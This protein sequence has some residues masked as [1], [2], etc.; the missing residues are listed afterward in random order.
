MLHPLRYFAEN[1]VIRKRL[2]EV[3]CNHFIEKQLF[4]NYKRL[5][6]QLKFSKASTTNNTITVQGFSLEGFQMDTLVFLFRDVFLQGTYYFKTDNPTPTILDC[7]ANIG[8][9]VLFFKW[10]YPN[11]IIHAF[12]PSPSIFAK[13]EKNVS[14]NHLSQ[15]F[16]HNVAL[17]DTKTTLSFFEPE[18]VQ[19]SLTGS[20][21]QARNAGKS[22]EVQAIKLSDFIGENSIS[23]I[24]YLKMDIEG[25]ETA[26][27][28]EM[29]ATHTLG[30]IKQAGI[31]YHH[32]I[33]G[34]D[35]SLGHFLQT[36]E[37][38]GF[39][40]NVFA[41]GL[42]SKIGEMQDVHLFLNQQYQK[43]NV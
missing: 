25:A 30:I 7:G 37:Q 29:A 11:A 31:E 16:C 3:Y 2:N 17:S 40:Y 42:P 43:N 41:E 38:E 33:A 39:Q 12:E 6:R 9:S 36:I 28:D 8:S 4:N 35:A 14:N 10:L 13:L 27:I 34:Q 22:V 32:Q 21:T 18:G 20:L 15:V 1:R 24:D 23:S 5:L 26:V 19:G